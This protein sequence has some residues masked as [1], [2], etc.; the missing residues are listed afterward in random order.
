MR[1]FTRSNDT[2]Q[3]ETI[4]ETSLFH[5]ESNLDRLRLCLPIHNQRFQH[6]SGQN[7]LQSVS[8]GHTSMLK[9][10]MEAL[11]WCSWRASQHPPVQSLVLPPKAPKP[12]CSRLVILVSR[13]GFSRPTPR[14]PA[15]LPIPKR[16]WCLLT[17]STSY[18]AITVENG[19]GS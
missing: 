5:I 16:I 12:P 1:H 18:D 7:T 8:Q 6:Q 9:F 17:D 2:G 4:H 14:R 10:M 11:S 3:C 19:L 15:H 13:Q